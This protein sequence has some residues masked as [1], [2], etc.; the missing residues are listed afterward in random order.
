MNDSVACP[1]R[2]IKNCMRI[3]RNWSPLFSYFPVQ[4]KISKYFNLVNTSGHSTFEDI[5]KYTSTGHFSPILKLTVF[6]VWDSANYTNQRL[7]AALQFSYFHQEWTEADTNNSQARVW[8]SFD[9]VW[10]RDAS[11]KVTVLVGFYVDGRC[12]TW[13]LITVRWTPVQSRH[14]TLGS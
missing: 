8:S 12:C 11:N 1:L 6:Y 10:P 2:Q 14:S 4:R 13:G 7:R 9:D 3:S 5:L